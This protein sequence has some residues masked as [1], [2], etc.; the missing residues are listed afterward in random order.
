MEPRIQLALALC[1]IG[2]FLDKTTIRPNNPDGKGF[3][4]KLHETQPDAPFS[5]YFLNF[6][7]PDN[8]KPGPLTPEIIQQAAKIMY[9]LARQRQ[10]KY[11][12]VAGVP[13]AGDPFAAAF[14]ITPASGKPIPLLR[15]GKQ[16]R[17]GGRKVVGV[18]DG[19]WN[20]GDTVLLIDDLIT[21]ADSK[22]EA[23]H[24]LSYSRL[25]V[26]DVLV[27]VD[28]EQGGP[29]QLKANLVNLHAVFTTSELLDLYV[30]AGRMSSALRDEIKAHMA[31]NS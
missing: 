1:D 16:E 21:Q 7:T 31:A 14:S 22:L 18:I 29:E 20:P 13:N 30:S 8:P 27:L 28:R 17:P 15:L 9:G 12:R 6:R 10:L 2:A 26:D 3:R 25:S 19:E 23:I 4:L 24:A 5:P 11:D